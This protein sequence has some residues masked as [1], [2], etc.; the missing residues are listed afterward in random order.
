M[1]STISGE[2]NLAPFRNSEPASQSTCKLRLCRVRQKGWAAHRG[3]IALSHVPGM[4]CELLPCRFNLRKA[5][6]RQHIVEGLLKA[7]QDLDKIVAAIRAAKDG[8]AAAAKL[9]AQFGLS[10]EQVSAL[11]VYAKCLIRCCLLFPAC[12]GHAVETDLYSIR[13]WEHEL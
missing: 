11:H 3:G 4:S 13:R 2:C 7:M 9:Q 1:T 10:P 6:K 12:N 8:S 5:Q